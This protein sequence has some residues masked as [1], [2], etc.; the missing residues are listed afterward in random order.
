MIL[1]GSMAVGAVF[2][3]SGYQRSARAIA[4]ANSFGYVIDDTQPYAWVNV[5]DGTDAG[6]NS[7]N[8]SIGPVPL[9]FNFPF[10][11]N[12]YSSVHINTNGLLTFSEPAPFA[13]ENRPIPH[14]SDPQNLVAPFWDALDVGENNSGKVYYKQVGSTFV[15]AWHDVT[16]DGELLDTMTFE[17]ILSSTGQI[18]YQYDALNGTLVS[19]T[20]GIEDADGINGVEYLYNA[21]GLLALVGTN[22]LCFI[23]PAA[24]RHVKVLPAYLGSFVESGSAEYKF[25]V[26]NTGDLGADTFDLD[27]AMSA[28]GW[29]SQFYNASGTQLLT[30]SNGNSLVDTG[31]LAAGASITVTARIS[32]PSNAE[33]GQSNTMVLAVSSGADPAQQGSITIDSAVPFPFAQT[34]VDPASGKILNLFAAAGS[35]M[36][37]LLD[38][39]IS[40]TYL[41][42][43]DL[44][45]SDYVT[46]WLE[47]GTFNRDV[48]VSVLDSK[49]NVLQPAGKLTDNMAASSTSF[50]VRDRSATLA[51]ADQNSVGVIWVRDILSNSVA[52]NSNIH[53]AVLDP[54]DPIATLS[55]PPNLTNNA[56]WRGSADDDI[57]LFSHPVIRET[58]DGRFALAWIDDRLQSGQTLRDVRFGIFDQNGAATTPVSTITSSTAG[59]R[60]FAEP[61]L[62]GLS[63]DRVLVAYVQNSLGPQEKEIHYQVFNTAGTQLLADTA[64]SGTQG[65]GPAVLQLGNLDI[66][67]AWIN[68]DTSFVQ[69]VVL[70]GVTYLPVGP[71]TELQPADKLAA[72]SLSV[73][74]S[75]QDGAVLTWMDDDFRQKLYY[76]V[77]DGSGSVDSGPLAFQ[78]A[79][80]NIPFTVNQFGYAIA[81]YDPFYSLWLPVVRR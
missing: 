17:V 55:N 49:G 47:S 19:S 4:A 27:P 9:G 53:F 59:S 50:R 7:G 29:T 58:T 54:G 70:D 31:S 42:I 43:T 69:F 22:K 32:A 51:A 60:L 25:A 21:P 80:S 35:T 33:S 71:V 64:I 12:T 72:T 66:L 63:G 10:F 77:I 68:P 1:L 73:A 38:A 28:S 18:C 5:T 56:S 75:G 24:G 45:N 41:A 62:A 57:P 3:A 78:G 6:F 16:R 20:V 39:D 44:P 81:P 79:G 34:V 15:V 48:E 30:D 37:I 8:F 14:L 46:A 11:E 52:T 76:T 65:T 2:L 36:S 23:P 74:E 40:N 13:G 26:K 67:L 61:Q